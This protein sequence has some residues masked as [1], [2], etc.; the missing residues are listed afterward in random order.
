M[1]KATSMLAVLVI[2]T[3]LIGG[4]YAAYAGSSIRP[5]IAP[6]D[7]IRE[8]EISPAFGWEE[9]YLND[10]H[11]QA[12]YDCP[13]EY[14]PGKSVPNFILFSFSHVE[15]PG[16]LKDIRIYL[17]YS[18]L[19]VSDQAPPS[20]MLALEGTVPYGKATG[21]KV[22]EVSFTYRFKRGLRGY[23][24]AL[25]PAGGAV[26]FSTSGAGRLWT[27][28]DINSFQDSLIKGSGTPDY[29]PDNVTGKFRYLGVITIRPQNGTIPQTVLAVLST[30]GTLMEDLQKNGDTGVLIAALVVF[31]YRGREVGWKSWHGIPYVGIR[32]PETT[33]VISFLLG[34]NA[35]T[36]GDDCFLYPFP[37]VDFDYRL[38]FSG[39]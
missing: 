14:A 34:D 28:E 12:I 25:N 15:G 31:N 24:Y 9:K 2:L 26:E 17:W 4:F 20:R 29:L 33:K 32:H 39:G 18:L 10:T 7:V 23:E 37:V 22:F 11:V 30:N 6:F 38:N 5:T 8:Y 27:V 36:I 16:A 3:A 13:L 19:N 21:E 1:K 35:E